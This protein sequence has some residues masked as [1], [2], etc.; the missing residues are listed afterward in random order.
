VGAGPH[1]EMAASG[2]NVLVRLLAA[3]C[4]LVFALLLAACGGGS[5]QSASTEQFD[6][7]TSEVPEAQA[8]LAA[9]QK[10]SASQSARVAFKATFAGGNEGELGGEGVIADHKGRLTMD[11]GGL[12]GLG[13]GQAEVVFDGLV[14]Y[15]KLPPGTGVQLPAGQEWFKLDIGKLG[16]SQGLDLSQLEQLNQSDPSQALD[17]L[18][19][20]SDDFHQIGSAEVRGESTTHYQG[21]IDLQRVVAEA[22][23]EVKDVYQRLLQ[24]SGAD[25]VPMD[26]WIGDDGFVRKLRFT[27]QVGE[28]SVTVDEELYDFGTDEQVTVPSDDDVIDITA[29]LGNS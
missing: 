25:S 2:K 22:A 28:S 21:T 11:L 18:Q 13:S 19:G 20:A 26:V 4:A 14:Y 8:I 7:S 15:M 9:G 5:S 29:L 10:T 6:I 24:L 1:D 12:A 23:P 17:L 27:E 16:E 3:C